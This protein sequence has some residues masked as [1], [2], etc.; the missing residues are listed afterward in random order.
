MQLW[1]AMRWLLLVAAIGACDF[2]TPSD[3][4]ACHV[5]PDCESGRECTN[6][7]CVIKSGNG[8]DASSTLPPDAASDAAPDADPFAAIAPMCI[9]A[10]YTQVAAAGGGYYRVPNGTTSWVNAETD[11]ANDVVGATHL[12]VLSSQAEVSYMGMQTGW[13]GLT[14]RATEGVFL[15]VTNEAGDLRPWASGQPDNGGGNEN[16]AQMKSGGQIDD[17]QC[18]NSHRYVCECDG[19]APTP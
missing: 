3:Q 12:I 7:F 10:G 6:G 16:C 19:H 14:D 1:A 18:G 13:I 17:D 2:P 15:N 5:T 4:Y 11:C 8:P 9:A